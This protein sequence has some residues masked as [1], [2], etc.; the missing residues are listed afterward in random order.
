MMP[1]ERETNRT[2][3]ARAREMIAWSRSLCL[4]SQ[5]LIEETEYHRGLAEGQLRELRE[6]KSASSAKTDDPPPAHGAD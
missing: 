6:I 4:E 3:R 5:L 2:L 1:S